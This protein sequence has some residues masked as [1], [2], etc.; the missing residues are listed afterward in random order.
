V[1]RDGEK[2]YII[3]PVDLRVATGVSE[4]AL[5][6]ASLGLLP[7]GQLVERGGLAEAPHRRRRLVLLQRHF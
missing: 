7:L 5:G 6:E 3:A 2:R 1:Y 4:L